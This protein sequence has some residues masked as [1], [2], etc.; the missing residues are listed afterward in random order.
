MQIY[1]VIIQ[2]GKNIDQERGNKKGGQPPKAANP[3]LKN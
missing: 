1:L 2:A 3:P